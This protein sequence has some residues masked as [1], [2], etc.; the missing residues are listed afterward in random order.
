LVHD[1]AFGERAR[2]A[3]AEKEIRASGGGRA[4]DGIPYSPADLAYMEALLCCSAG[5]V[6][7]RAART[8]PVFWTSGEQMPLDLFSFMREAG[9][10]FHVGCFLGTIALASDLV[11]I[12]LNRDSRTQM[13]QLTR[14]KGWATLNNKNLN[15]A[16]QNGL[17]VHLLLSSGENVDQPD[18]VTFVSRRNKVAHGNV[19]ELIRDLS[20]YCDNAE[21][22]ALDQLDKAER[23]LVEWFNAAPDVQERKIR[24]H[25]W[26]T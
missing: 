16:H 24:N 9:R 7:Q 21:E 19:L 15:V 17:P 4:T 14:M 10:C 13:A 1:Q 12:I 18:P 6:A 25:R 11:E 23:F 5:T 26:P 3:K 8:R 22:E 2:P 20:D